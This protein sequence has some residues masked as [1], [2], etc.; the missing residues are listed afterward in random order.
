MADHFLKMIQKTNSVDELTATGSDSIIPRTFCA[1]VGFH[2]TKDPP[3]AP[4]AMLDDARRAQ[5]K[6]V[7]AARW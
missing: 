2:S 3:L 1:S 6:R 5:N 4:S 7:P